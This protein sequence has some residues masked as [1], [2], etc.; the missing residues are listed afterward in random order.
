MMVSKGLP[1]KSGHDEVQ[2]NNFMNCTGERRG[3]L[4]L[5][6]MT[7]RVEQVFKLL[8]TLIITPV[9][10]TQPLHLTRFQLCTVCT[11]V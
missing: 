9:H 10:P 7:G 1:K 2:K 11:H 4:F 5:C 8:F 6:T 3:G